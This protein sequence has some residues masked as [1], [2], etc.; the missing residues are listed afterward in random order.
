MKFD[1]NR[2]LYTLYDHYKVRQNDKTGYNPKMGT[3]VAP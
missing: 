1:V 3:V 2:E